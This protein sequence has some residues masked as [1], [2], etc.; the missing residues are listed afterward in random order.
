MQK[1]TDPTVKAGWGTLIAAWIVF[2]M[3]IPLLSSVVGGVFSSIAF[4]V[5]IVVIAKGHAGHG[6]AQLAVNLLGS[7]VVYLIGLGVY[8]L[9]A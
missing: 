4:I 8:A 5:S 1:T 3:P 9:L 6:I 7:P 2:L